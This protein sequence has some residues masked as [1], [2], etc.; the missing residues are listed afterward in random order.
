V[1]WVVRKTMRRFASPWRNLDVDTVT[2]H[3]GTSIDYAYLSVD[4]AVWVV[5]VTP[6]GEIVLIRQYRHPVRDWC[7]EVPAGGVGSETREDAAARE[8]LEEIGGIATSLRHVTTFYPAPAHLTLRGHVFLALGVERCG[9]ALEETE[10]LSPVPVPAEIVFDMARR[11]EVSEG[12]SALA[13]L[14]CEQAIRA[15]LGLPVP[16]GGVNQQVLS[17]QAD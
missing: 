13:I 14:V 3:A 5:P 4:E 12:Q 10:L 9:A 2:T 6:E 7:L 1:P 17:R 16:S 11:G 8:L 15:E